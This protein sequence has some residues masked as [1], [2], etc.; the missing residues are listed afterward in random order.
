MVYLGVLV[1]EHESIGEVITH[2]DDAG[3]NPSTTSDSPFAFSFQKDLRACPV[4]YPK[5]FPHCPLLIASKTCCYT[6][7]DIIVGLADWVP[8]SFPPN[9]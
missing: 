1:N 9:A 8:N 2:V 4:R 5:H 6:T 3:S 7:S